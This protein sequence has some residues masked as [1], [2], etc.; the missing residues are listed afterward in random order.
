MTFSLTQ[1][2]FYLLFFKGF[3]FECGVDPTNK[4]KCGMKNFGCLKIRV[5]KIFIDSNKMEF[6]CLDSAIFSTFIRWPVFFISRD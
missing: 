6:S 5:G 1:I 3:L 4:T 2:S